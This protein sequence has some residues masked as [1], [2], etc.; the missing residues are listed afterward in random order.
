MDPHLSCVLVPKVVLPDQFSPDFSHNHFSSYL[1]Q[2]M[3]LQEIHIPKWKSI[4]NISGSPENTC[5]S[6]DLVVNYA[7]VRSFPILHVQKML[8]LPNRI[9]SWYNLKNKCSNMSHSD[10]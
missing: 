9:V 2:G 3:L 8:V 7:V 1:Y 5:D 6:Y 4:L 10:C